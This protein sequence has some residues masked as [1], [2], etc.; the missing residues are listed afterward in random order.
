MHEGDTVSKMK[1]LEKTLFIVKMTS[2]A[3]V[4]PVSSDF[5]KA[6]IAIVYNFS[7]VLQSSREKAKTMVKQFCLF[8]CFFRGGGKQYALWFM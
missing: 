4:R 6:P 7:L 2:S 5:W 3:M 1:I 8:I